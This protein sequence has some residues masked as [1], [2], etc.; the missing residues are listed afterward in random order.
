[1]KHIQGVAILALFFLIGCS[2][3]ND[4]PPVLP[5]ITEPAPAIDGPFSHNR[6]ILTAGAFDIA[7]SLITMSPVG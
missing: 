3:G 7:S 1:M 5:D 6:I 4:G 2:G